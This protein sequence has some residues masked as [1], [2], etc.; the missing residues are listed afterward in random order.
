MPFC[1]CSKAMSRGI[2]YAGEGDTLTASLVGSLMAVYPEVSFV[3]MFCPDWEKDI[4]YLNHMGESNISL[5]KDK[6]TISVKPFAYADSGDTAFIH[7]TYKGGKAVY[8]NLA[9]MGSGK[10][11][12]IVS[13]IEMVEYDA[14]NGLE[15]QV[16]GYFTA[17]YNV[18]DFLKNFSLAGGTHHSAMVYGDVKRDMETFA[19][20][21]GFEFIDISKK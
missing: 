17:G 8:I 10:Y 14:T 6:C 9:P 2:G 11:A 20:E 21:L 1:E 5:M 16:C 4:I 3:E 18:A 19:A 15:K 7:G 12:L 13:D